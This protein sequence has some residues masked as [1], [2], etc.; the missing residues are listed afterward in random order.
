MSDPEKPKYLEIVV[1]VKDRQHPFEFFD[2]IPIGDSLL[3]TA[4]AFKEAKA[5]GRELTFETKDGLYVVIDTVESVFI[6]VREM[7]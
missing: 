4:V 6:S 7:S 5:E 2:V 3:L 1:F